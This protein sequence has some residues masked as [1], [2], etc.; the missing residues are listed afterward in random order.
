MKTSKTS[1]II[2]II[3]C[4][5]MISLFLIFIIS[6]THIKHEWAWFPKI[7]FAILYLWIP[8]LT[9]FYIWWNNPRKKLKP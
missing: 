7:V 4:S 8:A 1:R 6:G 9:I 2:A 3:M 5:M